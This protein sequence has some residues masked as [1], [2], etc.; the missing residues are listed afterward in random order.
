MQIGVSN[1]G[2]SFSCLKYDSTTSGP[3]LTQSTSIP[4]IAFEPL[5]AKEPYL[6]R[7]YSG[8]CLYQLRVKRKTHAT[9]STQGT[10]EFG[11]W[12]ANGTSMSLPPD[13]CPPR[14]CG[15]SLQGLSQRHADFGAHGCYF[16]SSIFI[17][18]LPTS[19]FNPV[20]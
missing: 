10:R 1:S 6:R 8:E 7:Y 15:T 12:A 17:D 18:L 19:L 20:I 5:F 4:C 11:P 13:L 14:L 9:F 16:S 3:Q 2:M